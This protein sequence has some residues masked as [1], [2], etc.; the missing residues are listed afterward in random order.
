V[1][2]VF[3]RDHRGRE[4]VAEYL[5]HLRTVGE[6][7]ALST[8]TRRVELLREHG[9]NLPMP[10]GRLIDGQQRLYEVRFGNHRAA[11]AEHHGVIVMLHAWRKRTQQLDES[12]AQRAQLR[13]DNWR[14]Q[15]S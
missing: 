11:Y 3:W 8:F 6:R 4:P 10:F 12:E 15:P 9:P 13:L 14:A 5:T 1:E 7:S 2:V